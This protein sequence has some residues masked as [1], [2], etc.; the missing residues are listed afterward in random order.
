MFE[1]KPLLNNIYKENGK[2]E[3][4][5][6]EHS[7]KTWVLPKD[8]I[9][10]GMDMYQPSTVKGKIL[11]FL[12]I[13]FKKYEKVINKLGARTVKLELT[14]IIKS[15]ID[16]LYKDLNYQVA[17]YMGDTS[18]K[19]NDKATLQV[20][21]GKNILCYFKVTLDINNSKTFKKEI[22]ILNFLKDKEICNVPEVLEYK[23][24]NGLY[25]FG[26]STNKGVGEKLRL[27]ISRKQVKFIK[28]I[29]EKTQQE[30]EYKDTDFYGFVQYIKQINFE[31]KYQE[32]INSTVKIIEEKLSK[33][34]NLYSLSHGDF[35]PWN[36]YYVNGEIE[37]FDFE[38]SSYTMPQ[39]ID[40]FHYITQLSL[41][42]F[43]NEVG[44]T[45]HIYKNLKN[46][47][48]DYICDL[49]FTYMCYLVYIISFYK[50][51]T[52]ENSLAIEDKFDKWISILEYLLGKY[53]D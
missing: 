9:K 20:Y 36:V 49:D 51:R 14:D 39:Y 52:E 47:L 25:I 15:Q 18:S 7:D 43:N 30:L 4:I 46:M 33:K 17:G 44:K 41:L 6:F 35:T 48:G 1:N 16:G 19:Q 13:N 27:K 8:S 38:Y 23:E 22:E 37:A 34:K 12:V 11:K 21:S 24:I 40:V 50:Q 45:I 53:K 32:I 5:V 42:G 2:Q 28:K 31:G 29:A 10:L 3:Y 26:Q